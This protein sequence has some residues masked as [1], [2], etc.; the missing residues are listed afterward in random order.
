MAQKKAV[1]YYDPDTLQ[2]L[3]RAFDEAW[4][5]EFAN[6]YAHMSVEERRTRPALIILELANN[7]ERDV[8]D[9]K[10]TALEIMRLRE[11]P[12]CLTSNRVR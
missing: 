9:I 3:C 12:A 11:R 1:A 10:E 8:E 5:E 7:G 6:S 2:L 4:E